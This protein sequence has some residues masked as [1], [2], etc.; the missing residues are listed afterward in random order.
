[1]RVVS[2]VRSTLCA[3]G[4]NTTNAAASGGCA[5]LSKRFCC[6]NLQGERI[7]IGMLMIVHCEVCMMVVMMMW[8]GGLGPES[9]FSS[10]CSKVL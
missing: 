2:P 9:V 10:F 8:L 3:N 1:M 4:C 6:C 5:V 7:G